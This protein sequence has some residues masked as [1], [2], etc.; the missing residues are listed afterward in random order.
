MNKHLLKYIICMIAFG[1]IGIFRRYIPL[2]S[3]L[4]A[5]V[6]GAI[7]AAFIIIYLWIRKRPFKFSHLK[8]KLL[9]LIITG[10]VMGFNWVLLFEAY[11]YTTVATATLCYYMQPL[12]L[13][14]ISPVLFKERITS[15]KALC[16]TIAFIGMVLVS[17]ILTDQTS[18]VAN[19]K[20]VFLGLA[21]GFLYAVVVSLNK[22]IKDC[23]PYE[24]TAVELGSAALAVFPYVLLL[25]VFTDP[26]TA[27]GITPLSIAMLLLISV[28]HTGVI[29]V[30]YFNSIEY[31][32]MSQ[33]A[34]FGYIDP[35]VALVLSQV[36]LQEDMGITGLIGAILILGASAASELIRPKPAT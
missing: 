12:F 31:I 19:L 1:T 11:N 21:S 3:G 6:R 15:V 16:L 2:D 34:I 17:G 13:I 23:D 24:K 33:V 22:M 26:A 20:G 10:A 28:V 27:A 25:G 14:L 5:M 4:I 29:Y 35:V 32:K 8:G 30:M 18:G 7:G 9:P 36:I